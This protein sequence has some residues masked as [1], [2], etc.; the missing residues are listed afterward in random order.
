MVQ[1]T[2]VNF[3]YRYTFQLQNPRKI[4]YYYHE[5]IVDSYSFLPVDGTSPWYDITKD[6]GT[7]NFNTGDLMVEGSPLV[8]K[9]LGFIPVRVISDTYKSG[10][11]SFLVNV[12]HENKIDVLGGCLVEQL[13]WLQALRLPSV[14]LWYNY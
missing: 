8:R 1:F 13:L 2:N 5:L 6:S 14:T 7:L 4:Y 11:W 12:H 9:V 10:T 3:Y